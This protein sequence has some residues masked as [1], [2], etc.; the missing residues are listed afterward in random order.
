MVFH[1][2]RL[3]APANPNLHHGARVRRTPTKTTTKQKNTGP[4]RITLLQLW[5]SPS[6]RLLH[7]VGC[8]PSPRISSTHIRVWRAEHEPARHGEQRFGE[9]GARLLA[10][11]TPQLEAALQ[12]GHVVRGL[13]VSL[14]DSGSGS[15]LARGNHTIMRIGLS[16]RGVSNIAGRRWTFG[17]NVCDWFC[18]AFAWRMIRERPCEEPCACEVRSNFSRPRTLTPRL[19]RCAHAADPCPPSPTTM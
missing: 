14:D 10:Q 2:A 13:E 18:G 17:E 8:S 12:Q 7:P 15:Y 6:L 11:F 3:A 16:S 9:E 19:A 4:P 5:Y 1:C